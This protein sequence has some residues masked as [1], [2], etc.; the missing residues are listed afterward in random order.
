MSTH[1]KAAKR[2]VADAERMAWHDKALYAVREKRDRMMMTVPEWEELRRRSSEIKRHTLSRLGHYL[3]EFERNASANGMT[4]HWAKDAAEMN[5]IVWQLVREHGG[6]NLIKSK[7][8]LSEECGL[9]PY[10][11]ERGI[12]AVESDLGERIM[13][14]LHR[15]PSHIVLP[16]IAVRREEVGALF[17]REMGTEPGNSDPTYLTHAARRALRPKFL[18]ADISMTGV[19]FAVAS[20]VIKHTIHGDA[21]ITDDVSSIRNLMNM[22]YDIRR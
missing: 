14:L 20:S 16:A 10:L 2:F 22:N 17:E 8:M 18:G 12:D 7:S 13:Q 5:E 1:S 11:H 4:V 21:N 9:T 3:C 19:N 6:T 15:P